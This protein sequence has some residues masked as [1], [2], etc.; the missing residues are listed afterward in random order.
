MAKNN[1]KYNIYELDKNYGIGYT[2][3]TNQPFYF[4]LEDYDL[5]K[6]YCWSEDRTTGYIKSHCPNSSN[7]LLHRLVT[8]NEYKIVDHI[9]HNKLD[10][11]KCNLREVTKQQNSLN[12][13]S[14]VSTNTSGYTGV[15]FITKRQQW[16][17]EIYVNNKTINLGSY[18]NKED[19]IRA[20]LQAEVKYFGEF[21]PQ[22]HLFK[23]YNIDYDFEDEFLEEI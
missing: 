5:I 23:K 19:A 3:N 6:D 21:A 15:S 1:K 2:T 22:K 12:R 18:A 20:R 11:R 16:F 9:N 13:S 4:D 8:H 14:V 10:N 7:I 17:A